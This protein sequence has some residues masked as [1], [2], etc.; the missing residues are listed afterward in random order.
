MKIL[1]SVRS[2]GSVRGFTL[3]ELLVVIAIIAIL[4]A[5]LIPVF[6]SAKVA[7]KRTQSVS[8][9]K[10]LGTAVQMYLG[11][12]DD[13]YPRTMDTSTGSVETVGWWAVGNYQTALDPYIKQG[14][15]GVGDGQVNGRDKVWFDA[16][17]PDRQV[18]YM[19]GSYSANGF[20]TGNEVISQTALPTTS[21]MVFKTLREQ[22]WDEV[23]GVTLPGSPPPNNDPFWMSD[24]F[25]MCLDPWDEDDPNS[26]YFWTRGVAAPPCSIFPGE[27]G[28]ED[29]DQEI[30]GRFADFGESHKPRY[31]RGQN[32]L[33]A[34][35][36]VSVMPFERT[37]ESVERNMW[38]IR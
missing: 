18:N 22:N 35:T 14:R 24:Y 15:G 21:S 25:D 26:P 30:D 33:M 13:R 4:A 1:S 9:L 5:I 2:P 20:L 31:G 38:R 27:A 29:W 8:N 16:M 6:A 36:S 7:A 10:Q 19:W 11:D 23:V 32:Y 34:D 37:Y 12:Y 3:I 28:C 17:D